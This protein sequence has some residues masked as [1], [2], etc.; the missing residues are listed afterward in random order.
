MKHAHADRVDISLIRSDENISLT[1]EDN[2][3]GFDATNPDIFKGM[4]LN[5]LMSRINFLKGRVEF[6][7]HPNRGT[8]VS[9][10]IPLTNKPL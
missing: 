6:D 3:I 5:N 4:G 8:L 9:I 1:I 7:S 2:G 10:Y